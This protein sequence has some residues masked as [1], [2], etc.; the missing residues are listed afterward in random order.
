MKISTSVEGPA[1]SAVEGAITLVEI[2]GAIDAYTA[3]DLDKTLSA[4]IAQGQNR[5]IVDLAQ[6]DYISSAGLRVLLHAQQSARAGGGDVQLCSPNTYVR[7]VLEMA[8]MPQLLRIAATRAE[9]L[10][11][12]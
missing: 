2:Q 10:R 7:K 9:A 4:L 6:L 5:L 8:G 3:R 1:L 12:P 11:S